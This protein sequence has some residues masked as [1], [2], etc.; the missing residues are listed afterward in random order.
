VGA[1][2][3]GVGREALA[4]ADGELLV[5]PGVGVFAALS[6]PPLHAVSRPTRST[7]RAARRRRSG[8]RAT[9]A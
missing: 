5:V 9:T 3:V 7:G 4:D 6:E 8:V 2:F 1:A